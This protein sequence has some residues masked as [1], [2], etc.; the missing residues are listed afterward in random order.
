MPP[1]PATGP[2]GAPAVV[3]FRWDL[4]LADNPAI[5]H[6]AAT[7]RPVLAVYIHDDAADGVRPLGG[8]SRW[9][10]AGSL[11]ALSRDLAAI[12]GTLHVF[13]GPA[14]KVLARVV[15]AA[16]AADVYWNRRYSAP[17][18]R[19]DAAIKAAL[20][21]AGVKVQSFN[22][23]L[24]NEPWAVK[25]KAGT[26][27]K[28][29]TPYWRA[30]RETG[31]PPAPLSAPTS[32]TTAALPTI[33][34][35]APATIESLG[36][37][38]TRPDWAGEIRS[39]WTPGESGARAALAE[40]LD[41]PARGYGENRN[42]PDKRSTSRLS[43]HL[44]FGE[45]G[46]RQIWHAARTAQE[47]GR[48]SARPYDIEKFLTEIGWRE[49]S[50]HLLH[51]FPDLARSNFQMKFN[52]FPWRNDSAR[53]AAWRK[54]RTGYPIV[55]AG[56]R[57]LWRTGWM[58]NRVRMIVGSFLIKHLLVDWRQG[59]EWFWDTLVDA[60]P[61]SNAASWQWV[62]GSGADAAP[63]FRIFAPVL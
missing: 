54:G 53:L 42:R 26:P 5:T 10:L 32:L 61:A 39:A 36:L 55:D 23:A 2:S 38:P 19:Q 62:A 51:Q 12:G 16:G 59:E 27:L 45:I 60:D 57:E 50:Y 6:A 21:E 43:P 25:S 4:R 11:E 8:A 13:A 15:H 17:E 24:L 22:A 56:M 40:F 29:F 20:T 52:D 14:E 9:W 3:W 46:P 44:R 28:V 7:G 58:H 48:T 63:Y 35:L 47:S 37:R 34:G 49:F 30:A 1:S 33:D 18:Q 31:E 41:G